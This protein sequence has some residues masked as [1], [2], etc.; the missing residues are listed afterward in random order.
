MTCS[1]FS[2]STE[3]I[4]D[5]AGNKTANLHQY[6]LSDKEWQIAEQLHDTLKVLFVHVLIE[7]PALTQTCPSSPGSAQIFKDVMLY[8][9][10]STPTLAMVIPAMDHINKVLTSQSL[11]SDYHPV[12]HAAL[13]LSKKVLNRYYSATDHS[14]VYHIAMGK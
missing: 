1:H 10:R 4:D 2:F 12:I 7:P 11:D 8:F 13:G 14:E 6:E 3:A 9:S 5:I